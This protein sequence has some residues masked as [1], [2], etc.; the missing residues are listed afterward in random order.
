M[1]TDMIVDIGTG[2]SLLVL[3]T[4]ILINFVETKKEYKT[5]RKSIVET[6]SMFLFFVLIYFIIRSRIG[7]LG[8]ENPVLRII[9]LALIVFGCMFNV[10]GGYISE[11]LGKSYTYLQDTDNSHEWAL[12]VREASALCFLNL[13]VLWSVARIHE[14]YRLPCK[15]IIFVPFMFYRARQEEELLKQFPAYREYMKKKGMFLPR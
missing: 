11:Q 15:H 10:W 4:S 7:T 8:L 12:F 9:G 13:D 3:F 1:I 5:E 2:A 14:L 6:G